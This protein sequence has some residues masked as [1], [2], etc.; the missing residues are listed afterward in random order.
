[1]P[2]A[3]SKRK[4]KGGKKWMMFAPSHFGD[5]EIFL[6]V[7]VWGRKCICLFPFFWLATTDHTSLKGSVMG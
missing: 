6:W 4:E 1:M 5:N 3:P 7:T 2:L